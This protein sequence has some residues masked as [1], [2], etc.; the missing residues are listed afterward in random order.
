MRKGMGPDDRTLFVD[1][2]FH[3][4]AVVFRLRLKERGNLAHA[5]ADVSHLDDHWFNYPVQWNDLDI[6]PAPI[7]DAE[8]REGSL[9]N[10]RE[11]FNWFKSHYPLTVVDMPT[12]LYS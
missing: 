11:L 2:D 8:L 1:F 6:L 10:I 7:S 9:L 3:S 12:A 5:L 4:G